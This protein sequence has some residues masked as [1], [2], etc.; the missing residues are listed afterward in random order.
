MS[1]RCLT[2]P[3]DRSSL[4]T[5]RESTRRRSKLGPTPTSWTIA[6]DGR[7]GWPSWAFDFLV[8]DTC[9]ELVLKD[10]FGFAT[11]TNILGRKRYAHQNVHCSGNAVSL[12]HRKSGR[13][14][15]TLFFHTHRSLGFC[16]LSCKSHSQFPDQEVSII[17]HVNLF[18][19]M[20]GSCDCP[21]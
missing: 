5:R 9:P 10:S 21:P 18:Q 2:A 14:E 17:S 12:P 13:V 19:D 15:W 6:P 16:C 1:S 7:N 8:S 3:I 20:W 4:L 11:K